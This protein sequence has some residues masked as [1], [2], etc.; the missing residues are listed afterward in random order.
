MA[1]TYIYSSVALSLCIIQVNTN[2]RA[3]DINSLCKQLWSMIVELNHFYKSSKVNDIPSIRSF[4]AL[5]T[6]ETLLPPEYEVWR[7]VMIS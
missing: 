4:F 6:L 3:F 7:E 1:S 2:H 5:Y